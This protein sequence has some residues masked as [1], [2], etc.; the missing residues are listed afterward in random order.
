M[1]EAG[2]GFRRRETYPQLPL[3]QAALAVRKA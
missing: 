1:Q 2:K 3:R